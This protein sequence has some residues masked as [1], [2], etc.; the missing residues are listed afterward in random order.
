MGSQGGAQERLFYSLN[1]EG[2]VPK[3]HPLR[4]V[5]H[6]PDHACGCMGIGCASARS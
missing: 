5:D 2:H 1:L 4:G 3:D 6:F